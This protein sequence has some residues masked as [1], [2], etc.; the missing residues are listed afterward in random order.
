MFMPSTAVVPAMP[1][2]RWQKALL[3]T[4]LR[5][6]LPNRFPIPTRMLSLGLANKIGAW[7]VQQHRSQTHGRQISMAQDGLPDLVDAVVHMHAHLHAMSMLGGTLQILLVIIWVKLLPNSIKAVQ[8]V[9][10]VNRAVE[11]GGIDHAR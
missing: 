9:N 10:H 6:P 8:V 1:L 11:A 4:P 2:L 5:E 7:V 3:L